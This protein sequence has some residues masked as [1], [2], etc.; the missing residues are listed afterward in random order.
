VARVEVVAHHEATNAHAFLRVH[1]AARAGAPE[2]LFCK[3]L[4]SGA[5]RRAAIAA[6]GMGE[7]EVHFYSRLAPRLAM[8][9]P[10]VY[11]AR[12]EPESGAF[13]LLMEDLAHTGCTIPDGTRGVEV[14]AAA[15]AL[16][17]LAALHVRFED[18]ARRRSEAGWV[19]PPLHDPGYA[20]AMLAEGLAGHRARLGEPF[21]RVAEI[22]LAHAD[23]LHA[24]WLEGPTT[25]VHGD[26]HLGNLF[27]DGGR[28]GFLDWGI[29]STGPPLR[30]VSYFL[31]MALDVEVRRRSERDLLRHYL[32]RRAALG[33]SPVSFDEAWRR[34]RE[35]AAYCV[36]ASCQIARFPNG[37]SPARE[38]FSEAFLARARAAVEDLDA[39]GALRER[40]LPG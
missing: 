28:T 34:H 6:T 39:L 26:P 17:D 30:D 29:V 4:P 2:R 22:Y 35:Q 14:D 19:A 9:V 37:L 18:P 5:E 10:E 33:G 23:A 38:R 15:G 36:V 16:A 12:C 24:L 7:R 32:D 8:R 20:G 40:G 1:Y 27:D 21:A 25:V 3:L 11:F 13:V 31:A